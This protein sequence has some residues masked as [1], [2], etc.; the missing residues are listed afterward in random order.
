MNL[1]TSRLDPPVLSARP[2][3]AVQRLRQ[4]AP[5]VT[6]LLFV[7]M[8]VCYPLVDSLRMLDQ[9]ALRDLTASESLVALR[10]SVG[11]ALLATLAATLT[12][13]PLAWCCNRTDMHGRTVISSL[14]SISF[15]MPMLASCIAYIFLFGKNSGILNVWYGAQHGGAPLYDIYSF[16]GIV[17][18]SALHSYPLVFMSTLSGLSRMNVELEES[19]RICGMSARR[20]FISITLGAVA[21]AVLAGIAF[22]FADALTM[23]AAPLLLGL[24]IGI[25]F[26]TTQLFSAIVTNPD[27]PRA[28]ALSLP[29]IAVTIVS[30][31]IQRRLLGAH[32]RVL[33]SGKG[34]RDAPMEL[35][36]WKLP[37]LC[38]ASVPVLLSLIVPLGALVCAASMSFWWK[39]FA[40][41]N[42]SLANFIYLLQDDETQKAIGNSVQLAA[43]CA[44]ASA[45]IGALIALLLW[46]MPGRL[47]RVL[48]GLVDL[49]LGVPHVVVG[50]VTL[51]AWF[52]SPFHLGGSIWILALGY[53]MIML[54]YSVRTCETA[55]GQIDPAL[56]EAARSIGMSAFATWRRIVL[57]L[58]R[59]G[60]VTSGV[61]VFLFVLKEFS[62]TA[63]VY[64]SETQTLAIRVYTMYDSGSYEKTATAAVL[65]VLLTFVILGIT[66]FALRIAPKD[67]R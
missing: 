62:F 65:L 33:V 49:P 39:G 55:L 60:I 64:S 66:R 18:M 12:G 7:G 3:R 28:I 23:L 45:L 6:L 51:L 67:V 38:M 9:N 36:G 47:A 27:L 22:A 25:P 53:L 8:L 31:W 11:A 26:V 16:S 54:P 20:V 58:I 63:M 50:V 5:I 52:G 43:S 37:A 15:V 10:N 44:I 4:I 48:R 32:R 13:V 14:V 17:S 30:L 34:Q 56:S 29:L 46:Q 19:A 42:F 35:G 41:D 57:P 40:A 2:S 61:L 59:Q 1:S 21:P 24:P